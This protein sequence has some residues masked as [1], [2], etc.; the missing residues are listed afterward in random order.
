MRRYE[1][2]GYNGH[3]LYAVW[4]AMRSRCHN[5]NFHQYSDY[6]GRGIQ[7]C[8]EWDASAR[9]FIDWC[10]SH[11]WERGLTLDRRENSGNYSPDNCRFLTRH[12]QNHNRRRMSRMPRKS[13]FPMGVCP[14]EGKYFQA[15]ICENGKQ[16]SLGY[17]KT[18]EMASDIYQQARRKTL[19]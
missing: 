16:R 5:A 9:V 10:L 18:P 15:L 14:R 6:G 7:V 17:F 13:P 11:G 8:P 2:H 1:K 4:T 3:P 19:H 12:Q